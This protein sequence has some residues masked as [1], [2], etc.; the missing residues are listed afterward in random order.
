[1]NQNPTV[2]V[3]KPVI[4]NKI[5]DRRTVCDNLNLKDRDIKAVEAGSAVDKIRWAFLE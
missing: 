4:K 2:L 1:M 5:S 3:P